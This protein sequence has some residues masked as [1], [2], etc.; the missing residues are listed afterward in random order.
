MLAA[1]G[2]GTTS[3]SRGGRLV[4]ATDPAIERRDALRRKPGAATVAATITAAPVTVNIG[5]REVSTW[6]FGDRPSAGGIRAKVGDLIEATFVNDL[7]SGEHAALARHRVAQRHGRCARPDPDAGRA[8]GDVHV[9]V[10]RPGCRDLLVPSAHGP[11]AGPRPVRAVDHRGP[12]RARWPSDVDVTLMLD[13]WLD[14]YGRSAAGGARRAAG[15]GGHGGHDMGD[16]GHRRHGHGRQR[17]GGW[18][19]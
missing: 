3:S 6:A 7:T 12:E 2:S 1:C 4:E 13:D 11:R 8:V 18:V 10:H 19:R 14:G 5:G 15:S 16:M 9:P 17:M